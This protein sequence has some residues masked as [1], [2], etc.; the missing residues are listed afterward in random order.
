MANRSLFR[1]CNLLFATILSFSAQPIK[2]SHS[3]NLS[4]REGIEIREHSAPFKEWI[5]TNRKRKHSAM[6]QSMLNGSS[7]ANA[8]ALDSFA[9]VGPD[10]YKPTVGK[11]K[12]LVVIADIVLENAD[13]STRT[14]PSPYRTAADVEEIIFGEENSVAKSLRNAS[15]GKLSLDGDVTGDGQVDVY[16]PVTLTFNTNQK[17]DT[18]GP[19][20]EL[21]GGDTDTVG[22]ICNN[23]P[24]SL[25][26]L[27]LGIPSAAGGSLDL[28]LTLINREASDYSNCPWYAATDVTSDSIISSLEAP[29]ATAERKAS[30]RAAIVHEL[31]HVVGLD[32]SHGFTAN[33]EGSNAGI[34][35]AMQEYGDSTCLMGLGPKTGASHYNIP[36]SYRLGW[37]PKTSVIEITKA[38]S[39]TL[40]IDDPAKG[41]DA[42]MPTSIWVQRKTKTDASGPGFVVISAG[43]GRS[44]TKQ[45]QY[46]DDPV[47][48]HPVFRGSENIPFGLTIHSVRSDLAEG[49][50]GAYLNRSADSGPYLEGIVGLDESLSVPLLG[51]TI[52][53]LKRDGDK[54]LVQVDV[55]DMHQ[56]FI[57]KVEEQAPGTQAILRT[58]A[59]SKSSKKVSVKASSDIKKL[60]R[61]ARQCSGLFK[62][63]MDLSPASYEA[64]EDVK[65]VV[66]EIQRAARKVLAAGSGQGRK[67]VH[68]LLRPVARRYVKYAAS[69][70]TALPYDSDATSLF[71]APSRTSVRM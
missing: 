35:A 43:T 12:M 31:G 44:L 27:L 1:A 22:D 61:L 36:Q 55:T 71:P 4:V 18:K 69:N 16:G 9:L 58:I 20:P 13:G 59:M 17:S 34:R 21:L 38:G 6:V 28:T 7:T 5:I 67:L 24:D 19:S 8:T 66:I 45:L 23:I 70:A 60:S 52:K 11:K 47:L 51:V 64:G 29:S 15:W 65:S 63:E 68:T 32:H 3:Q 54:S 2:P 40:T 48:G 56:L 25:S 57:T 14:F 41:P 26:Y 10:V 30:N 33:Y 39:Y 62:S 49:T 46:S 42:P 37:L 53:L 50:D